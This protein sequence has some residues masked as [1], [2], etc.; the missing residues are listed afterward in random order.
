MLDESIT[1]CVIKTVFNK[2][3]ENLWMAEKQL[4]RQLH[5]KVALSIKLFAFSLTDT[6]KFTSEISKTV[7]DYECANF[8]EIQMFE[9]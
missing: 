6:T 1:L 3:N 2:S 7:R 9:A 4:Y 5:V 8:T